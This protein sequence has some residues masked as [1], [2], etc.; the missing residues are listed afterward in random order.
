VFNGKDVLLL[1]GAPSKRLWANRYNG[2][3]GHVE[4]SEDVYAAAQRETLEE[5]GLVVR[6]LRLR[7]VI[8]VDAGPPAADESYTGIL[9]FCFSARSDQRLTHPSYEGTLEWVSPERLGG[10]ELVE[11]LPIL[12]QRIAVTPEDDRPFFA[13]Y[14]YDENDRLCITFAGP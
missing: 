1:K 5:T 7:G 8:N 12:L 14:A 2:V 11:D 13:R 3:G 9:I 10:L 6:D 4:A